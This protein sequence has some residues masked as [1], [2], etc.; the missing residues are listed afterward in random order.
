MA[1]SVCIFARDHE[2]ELPRCL[3]ALDD[4]GAGPDTIVNVIDYGSRDGTALVARTLAAA[5]PRVR[6]H[7]LALA[8]KAHAWND[9][10]HRLAGDAETHVFIDAC[11]W[12]SK[13]A[14]KALALALRSSSRAYAA[15]GIPGAGRSRKKWTARLLSE[16]YISSPL[17]AVRGSALEMFRQ[18]EIYLPIG[19]IGEDGLLSYIFVTDFEGGENDTRRARIAIA[20]GAFF[21]FDELCLNAGDVATLLARLKR[22]SLRYFQNE[23]LYALL[24]EKG[25]AAMPD[26]IDALCTAENLARLAPRAEIASYVIDR[27]TLRGLASSRRWEVAR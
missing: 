5:D 11:A 20:C 7:E 25:L 4:A 6:V 15:A 23:L 3:A 12:P 27:M 17:Y 13:G 2:H 26:R 19:L 9:Y 24:K 8:D 21:E 18:R 1:W 14:L 22:N 16:H 10:V